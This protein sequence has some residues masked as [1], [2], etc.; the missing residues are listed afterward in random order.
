MSRESVHFSSP[1]HTHT[2]TH[3]HTHTH[4]HMYQAKPALYL[5]LLENLRNLRLREKIS[6]MGFFFFKRICNRRKNKRWGAISMHIHKALASE[7]RAAETPVTIVWHTALWGRGEA[8][9]W[10][11]M[12]PD[13]GTRKM[14][15]PPAAC[16]ESGGLKKG[17]G[18]VVPVLLCSPMSPSAT[19]ASLYI[20]D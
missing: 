6:R 8:A 2:N 3:T 17:F 12:V 11:F 20:C 7:D 4:W 14:P 9:F 1:A 15:E 19:A 18:R 5:T 16:S 13:R 10:S